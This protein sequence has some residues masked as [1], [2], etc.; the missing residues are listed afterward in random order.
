VLTLK[1][2][3]QVR[4]NDD[5]VPATETVRGE[6]GSITRIDRFLTPPLPFQVSEQV[7]AVD[8]YQQPVKQ[9]RETDILGF[10]LQVHFSKI[11]D[12]VAFL[13]FRPGNN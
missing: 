4:I 10:A 6:I 8:R 2:G 3:D 1:E 7:V 9:P 5:A 12:S 11:P 13:C